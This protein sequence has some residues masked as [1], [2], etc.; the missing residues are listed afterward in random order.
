MESKERKIAYVYVLTNDRSNVLYVGATDN[1]K[2]GLYHH[3]HRL[4]PGFT[5][6]YNVHR[7]VYYELHDSMESARIREKQL[8][9][10]TRAKKDAVVE[11]M[12]PVPRPCRALANSGLS[13]V[14]CCP[15]RTQLEGSHS[16]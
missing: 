12:N 10:K 8:K 1:L 14:S 6:K 7:L 11:S 5:K 2:S 13:P 15:C 4:V 9:G 3:K 16:S